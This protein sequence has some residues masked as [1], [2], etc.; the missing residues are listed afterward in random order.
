MPCGRGGHFHRHFV[1]FQLAQHFIHGHGIAR[2]LEP[3]CHCG[4]AHTLAQGGNHH[5]HAFQAGGRFGRRGGGGRGSA[6][7]P[8]RDHGQQRINANCLALGGDNLAQ[9]AGNGRGHFNSN[10]VGFQLAEHFIHGH[11]I[12]RLFE[13]GGHGGFGNTFAQSGDS[14]FGGHV[15]VIPR[16]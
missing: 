15:L 4:L 8:F 12:A 10:L 5:I 14:N 13:P 11:G 1:G 3:A 16:L 6:C 7:P 9:C 2:F